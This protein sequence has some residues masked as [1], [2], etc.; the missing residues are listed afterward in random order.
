MTLRAV[1]AC[2]NNRECRQYTTIINGRK[3]EKKQ[4]PA[5]EIPMNLRRRAGT[6]PLREIILKGRGA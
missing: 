2:P 3:Q 6:D 1:P 5:E 4:P